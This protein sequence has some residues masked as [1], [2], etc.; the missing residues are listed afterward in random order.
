MNE[1]EQKKQNVK[2]KDRGFQLEEPSKNDVNLFSSDIK[3]V[4]GKPS[5]KKIMSDLSQ[6]Y[7]RKKKKPTSNV[8]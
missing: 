6:I 7:N 1:T 4:K 2:D 3:V 5:G 8:P